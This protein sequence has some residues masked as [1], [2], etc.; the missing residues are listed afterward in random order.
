M[1]LMS[2]CPVFW[3]PASRSRKVIYR[4][5]QSYSGYRYRQTQPQRYPQRP[6]YNRRVPIDDVRLYGRRRN[7][8]RYREGLSELAGLMDD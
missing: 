7:D 3:V 2:P 6:I 1:I 4:G 8:P 5:P